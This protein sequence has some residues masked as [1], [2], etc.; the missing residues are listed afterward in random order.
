MNIWRCE[1]A[2]CPPGAPQP[3]HATHSRQSPKRLSH[4]FTRP[5]DGVHS[6]ITFHKSFH[7]PIKNNTIQ[8][9]SLY[10]SPPPMYINRRNRRLS[11]S[12]FSF[13]SRCANSLHEGIVRSSIPYGAY[14]ELVTFFFRSDRGSSDSG[15]G[16]RKSFPATDVGGCSAL[17]S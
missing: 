5:Q 9:T 11:F 17:G 16:Y 3:C 15:T 6:T 8:S 1:Q 14:F 13:P 12:C 10:R 4:A 7:N 2:Q